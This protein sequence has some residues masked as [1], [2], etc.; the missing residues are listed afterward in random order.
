LQ[1]LVIPSTVTEMGRCAFS[2]CS[3]LTE[4]TIP[5]SVTKIEERAF[6]GCSGLTRVAILSRDTVIEYGAFLCGPNLT[7]VTMPR[8][9]STIATASFR[10]KLSRVELLEPPSGKIGEVPAPRMLSRLGRWAMK[11]TGH[12]APGV[13]RA[14]IEALEDQCGPDV[15]IVSASLAGWRFGSR[16]VIVAA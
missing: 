2:W 14:L 9:I 16:F 11:C 5:S 10:A 12:S 8:G 15:K 7:H 4:L 1:G 6:D 13:S 3:A